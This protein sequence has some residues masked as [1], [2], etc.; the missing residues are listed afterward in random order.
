[1]TRAEA[2][3]AIG[4]GLDLAARAARR[5][6]S[7][8][9]AIGEMGIGNTTAASA[10]CAA[11]TGS[12][13]RRGDRPRDRGRRR[14]HRRKV[15]VIERASRSTARPARPDRACS[16]PSAGSRSRGLVGVIVGGGRGAHPGRAR[17]L[18]HRRRGARRRG[19]RS[20]ASRRA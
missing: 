14:T 6:A 15:A 10:L 18:H 8:C 13:R 4:V 9:S 5:A 11:L 3:R 12:P 19:A 1:M 20:R 17:R 16:R 7:T 2:L